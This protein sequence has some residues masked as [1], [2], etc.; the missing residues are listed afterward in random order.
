MA[1]KEIDALNRVI[2]EVEQQR[3]DALAERTSLLKMLD[4]GHRV[5]AEAKAILATKAIMPADVYK[6]L[7]HLRIRIAPPTRS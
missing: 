4:D 3:D 6:T 7:L 5:I 1:E 2:V